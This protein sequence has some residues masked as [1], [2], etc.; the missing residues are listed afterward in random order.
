MA[1]V[2]VVTDSSCDLPQELAERHG[3]SVVPLTIRFGDEEF[4]D[5]EELSAGEFYARMDRADVLP[6]TAAPAPGA[7]EAVFRGLADDGA[8]GIVCVNLSSSLSATIES[9]RTAAKAFDGPV[10]V[11]V[12]DSRS[13]TMGLGTLCVQAAQAAAGGAGVDDVVAQVEAAVPRTRVYGALDTLDNLRKGGRIGGAQALLG[14]LLSI[15]PIIDVSTGVVEAESK[16]RT[17]AR[18]LR[19]LVD[20]VTEHGRVEHL[21]VM[22][23]DAPDAEEFLDLL[24]QHYPRD[25]IVVGQIGATIGAHGG[26]RVMGV[27]FQVPA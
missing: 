1:G 5:R 17:R 9:A 25:E 27:T 19:H 6:Q 13:I 4:V 8:D 15:K 7:F 16:Q 2:R 18:A 20:R 22:H 24:A 14:S 21:A 26:P 10:P 3:I 23:G 11:R 12:V